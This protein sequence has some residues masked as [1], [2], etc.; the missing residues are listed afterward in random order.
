MLEEKNE[1]DHCV[2]ECSDAKPYSYEETRRC[3]AECPRDTYNRTQDQVCLSCNDQCQRPDDNEKWMCSDGTNRE[4]SCLLGCK[5]V[6]Q[7]KICVS[8]CNEDYVEVRFYVI[9]DEEVKVEDPTTQTPG[10]ETGG[11]N[12][13]IGKEKEMK[14]YPIKRRCKDRQP[15]GTGTDAEPSEGLVV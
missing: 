5:N 14:V 11:E 13:V 1:I 3:Y 7:K 9:G 10:E 2:M 6:E 15:E 4:G 12:E 8:Q